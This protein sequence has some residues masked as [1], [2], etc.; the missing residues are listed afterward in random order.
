MGLVALTA[1]GIASMVG[2][3]INVVPFM[4]QRNVPG[5]GAWVLPAF[6][7][8]AIPAFFAGVAYAI[9]ASA[10][11]RAG[12]S[13]VYASRALH[14]YLG[15]IASFS[16]WF[17]IS[18]AIGLVSYVLVPFLRDIAIAAGASGA[19]TAL[20]GGVARLG[21]PLTMLWLFALV[22]VLGIKSYERVLVPLLGLTFLLGGI[23]IVAGFLFT[24]DDFVRAGGD[25]RGARAG[26]A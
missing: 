14:P 16:Q 9:L 6:F 12:G 10:M 20:E 5:I 2:A 15:F 18:V 7:F 22:N 26:A 4:I 17:A 1:T 19:A 11:P 3:G 8:A 21:I 25:A 23:V 13:Y 24:Q